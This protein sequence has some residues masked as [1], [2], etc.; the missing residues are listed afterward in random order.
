MAWAMPDHTENSPKSWGKRPLISVSR[1]L[2]SQQRFP[3]PSKDQ[4]GAPTQEKG[5]MSQSQQGYIENV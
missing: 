3:R 5:S 2:L 4:P 1:S